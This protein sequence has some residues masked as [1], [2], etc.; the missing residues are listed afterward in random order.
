MTVYEFVVRHGADLAQGAVIGGV[1]IALW[2]GWRVLADGIAWI[3]GTANHAMF[4]SE[5]NSEDIGLLN[6]EVDAL[7]TRVK[8]LEDSAARSKQRAADKQKVRIAKV[9]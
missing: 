6:N 5:G 1:L 2:V 4:L 3:N 9:A 7:K 8:S